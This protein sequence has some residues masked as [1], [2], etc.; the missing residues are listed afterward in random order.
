[1]PDLQDTNKNED[2][3]RPMR[4]SFRDHPEYTAKSKLYLECLIIIRV[5]VG[6]TLMSHSRIYPQT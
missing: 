6:L 4:G 5:R 3:V 1:M 2:L